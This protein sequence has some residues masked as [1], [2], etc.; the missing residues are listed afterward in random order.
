[1]PQNSPKV[2]GSKLT[3][4]RAS[5]L[6]T[7]LDRNQQRERAQQANAELAR[8]GQL[9][10]SL[11]L[12]SYIDS[13]GCSRHGGL[14][15]R[16]PHHA[17]PKL[18][19]RTGETFQLRF[20]SSG[21]YLRAARSQN[22]EGPFSELEALWRHSPLS[23]N[24]DAPFDDIHSKKLRFA[25]E[26]IQQL[27]SG[28]ILAE[29]RIE[30]VVTIAQLGAEPDQWRL[31]DHFDL[32]S[33]AA[34]R[35]RQLQELGIRATHRAL[36]EVVVH[37]L[38]SP[39]VSSAPMH[40]DYPHGSW[41]ALPAQVTGGYEMEL[42]SQDLQIL[43]T[44]G[45]DVP[46]YVYLRMLQAVNRVLGPDA[47]H[48][49]IQSQEDGMRS[50]VLTDAKGR[51]WKAVPEYVD[52]RKR[53]NG[54]ELVSPPLTQ[55]N[56]KLAQGARLELRRDFIAGIR[57]SGHM[58]YDVSHLVAPNLD[59][60]RLVDL[61][62]YIEN[63]WPEIYSALGPSRYGTILNRFAVPLA[64]NQQ[65][66]LTD[67]SR[68]QD[69]HL[70]RV[71]ELFARYE[72]RERWL[73]RDLDAIP[74]KT[75]A[76]S[77]RKIFDAK[78]P[79]YLLEFRLGDLVEPEDFVQADALFRA[80]ITRA[81][82]S[83]PFA[84]I[85]PAFTSS[86]RD[87][88]LSSNASRSV[89][90]LEPCNAHV[91]ALEDG[92]Y[93]QFLQ[94]LGL[95]PQR[96]PR[97]KFAPGGQRFSLK[98]IDELTQGVNLSE[99]IQVAGGALSF[100]FETE[101]V[102]GD[103]TVELAK[104][105][106]VNVERFPFLAKQASYEH[107]GNAEVKSIPF[108]LPDEAL[109][110]M[111]D[112]QQ[113]LGPV[114]K[115]FHFSIHIPDPLLQLVGPHEFQGWISRLGD[116]VM[117]WRLER[118]RSYYALLMKTQR[119]LPPGQKRTRGAVRFH[120]VAKNR[121]R[122]ELRGFMNSTES[123]RETV[124]RVIAALQNPMLIQGFEAQQHALVRPDPA[125]SLRKL[126]SSMKTKGL[127]EVEQ[128][129]LQSMISIGEYNLSYTEDENLETWGHILPLAGLESAPYLTP[130]ERV[131]FRDAQWEFLQD[132]L[133]LV[134]TPSLSVTRRGRHFRERIA[135]WAREVRL[136]QTLMNSLLLRP[137]PNA[138]P[139][140]YLFKKAVRVLG[141][142]Q[143]GGRSLATWVDTLTPEALRSL[144][145]VLEERERLRLKRQLTVFSPNGPAL[146]TVSALEA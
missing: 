142:T 73:L 26:L 128:E 135:Q 140:P 86:H 143:Q 130:Y 121:H 18:Y 56:V 67:L 71:A 34:L 108:E 31:S 96:Y 37:T 63:H 82:D 75:R 51:I 55:E 43:A 24:D 64:V 20:K 39:E 30:P 88:R 15:L 97:V 113:T 53:K 122:V 132:T 69:R 134:E 92:Q 131:L 98:E 80:L 77:Y 42:A 50:A 59:A 62:V 119:R 3:S 85:R 66:L 2:V 139:L 136:H 70:P 14:Y 36:R 103:D 6:S 145:P 79:P 40:L 117:A 110:R 138:V 44:R 105:W 58:T 52:S 28:R 27:R 7:W 100:G 102:P 22:F 109:L 91:Q 115:G 112:L 29:V 144:W 72:E 48:I 68:L 118:R 93:A 11:T 104:G 106:D 124:R 65:E 17:T 146:S 83:E 111:N 4:R 35:L 16:R 47:G 129:R 89:T 19:A 116:A 32:S 125:F 8:Y 101:F 123:I 12:G 99:P 94:Q 46:D 90:Q 10:L 127:S 95:D 41:S 1:M 84:S 5:T 126:L 76:A 9:E 61:I 23:K 25:A 74:F 107:S 141:A 114:L 49:E 54:L 81:P 13:T 137:T 21:F 60:T 38:P 87:L 133:V 78:G 33:N 120:P 57:S 45:R